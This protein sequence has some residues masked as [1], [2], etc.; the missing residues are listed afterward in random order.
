VI[1]A[2]VVLQSRFDGA[3]SMR[4]FQAS[5]RALQQSDQGALL[6]SHAGTD[7]SSPVSG[8]AAAE[9]L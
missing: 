8:T 3:C 2:C 1:A 9:S 4:S 5:H 7:P 6:S